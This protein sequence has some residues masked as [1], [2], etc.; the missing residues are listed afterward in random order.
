MSDRPGSPDRPG[1]LDNPVAMLSRAAARKELKWLAEELGRH[2]S[3]YY[4]DAAPEIS[5][6]AY[7]ELRRRNEALEQRFPDLKRVDSPSERVGAAPATGFAKV[8]HR[9]PM[10]SLGNAFDE[11]DVRDFVARVRRFLSL[12]EETPL[13]LVAEPKIDGL[14]ISLRYEKGV[15]VQGATRGDG[16]EG[17]DVTANLRTIEE[18][19]DELQ[20]DLPDVFEVRGEVYM[21]KSDFRD[22]NERQQ[23]AGRKIFANPRN[24]AAGSLR[25]LDPEITRARP[26]RCFLYAAGELS[27]PVAGTHWDYLAYLRELGFKTNPLA[28]RCDG[29]E[30]ILE[31]YRRIEKQRAD[32]DYDIDGVVYKVD[33]Y[34]LQER[35]GFVS[36][37]PR[38]AIA[39]KFA[40]EQAETT[41]EKIGIQVGRTGALTP[42][43]HLTPVTVGGVVVA[44]ATLH[45]QD[46][47]KRKDVREGDRVIVQR[48]GDVIPQIV[49]VVDGGEHAGRP[50]YVF[51]SR[52]PCP[53][54]TEVVRPEG[55]AVTRCSGEL[56]CPHQQLRRL[57]HFVSR[58]AFDIEGLGE[59]QV[60]VFFDKGLV[61]TPPDIF[62]LESRDGTSEPPLREWEGWGERS[63]GKLFQAIEA[64]RRIPL[65]RFVYA[66]G[67][68]Q[69]GQATAR[70]LARSYG[71]LERW[72]E[73]MRKVAEER[74]AAPEAS[75]PEQV[76]E[77]F[78]ELCN[79]SGIGLSMADDLAAFFSEQHNLEVLEALEQRLEVEPAAAPDGTQASPLSGKTVVFTGSLDTMSRGEAKARAEAL[80]AR[81]TGSVSSSTDFLVVGADAGSKARKAS[82][83]GVETLS[84]EDWL[85]LLE[86]AR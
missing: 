9:V 5:D 45:N 31:V 23:A 17:E 39:H 38:W 25:Q 42:V 71:T 14:S 4:Q 6:A 61:R 47:I 72:H 57:I 73:A 62:D 21:T 80:G 85:K 82:E 3:L 1:S 10:L 59:K 64:R 2:D 53:L 49:A 83:L 58:D 12:G 56:A 84:E 24:A 13:A 33:R 35:L 22:L 40:A 18:I 46:E 36:R 69:V 30:A 63:A 77:A 76:G 70:L 55:E 81:V 37:A 43:A 67:I 19:P 48:A 52:C 86:Q 54:H 68:R 34:D 26:L 29:A 74:K 41:L 15:F 7:D 8:R 65:E 16:A 78:A 50:E 51:P 20:G 44:R 27:R 79:L 11:A 66:L 28:E 75:K 60:E 32:L